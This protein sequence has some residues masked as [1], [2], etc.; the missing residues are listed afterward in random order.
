MCM[1]FASVISLYG[2]G[3]VEKRL[4]KKKEEKKRSERRCKAAFLFLT[5]SNWMNEWKN[6]RTNDQSKVILF[7]DSAFLHNNLKDWV[8]LVRIVR[9]MKDGNR[10]S[11]KNSR[12][13]GVYLSFNII[14]L[15]RQF[16]RSIKL[17]PLLKCENIEILF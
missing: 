17:S 11:V 13:H 9:L 3:L 10:Q 4:T 15:Q 2:D 1:G 16:L 6:E 5:Y 7:D 8:R 14:L 12:R